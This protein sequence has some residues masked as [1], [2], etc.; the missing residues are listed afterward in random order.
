MIRS[1]TGYGAASVETAVLRASA[2]A[3]S[4]NHRFLE[5]GLRV[6]R[7]LAPLEPE[8]KGLVQSRVARGR[9]D[10]TVVAT[11]LAG[12]PAGVAINRPVIAALVGAL[13]SVQEEFELAGG[14]HIADVARFPGVVEMTDPEGEVAAAH[15]EAVLG[16]IEKA[17]GELGQMRSAEGRALG[18]DV[19]G[20]LDAIDAAGARIEALS[21]EGK[22]QRQAAL[23]EKARS[24]VGELGLEEPRLY[25]EVAR[26]VDR[27]DVAEELQRL[28][29]HVAQ[30]RELLLKGGA[31]GKTFDF[32]A[33]EMLREATTMGSKASSA[34][35]VGQVV[36]L[37]S[38]VER[39]RE[40]AQNVE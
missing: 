7:W 32:L 15:R 18:A 16:V 36:G 14:L 19:A 17:L 2:Q 28:R 1:M 27:S 8:I 5:V 37:K 31:C 26:L 40:Q 22:A 11:L 34:A 12:T 30:T 4:V 25:Q 24:L 20:L 23:V 6:P 29:S 13:R 39:F 9:V 10:V 33:Q 21:A 3:K 35:M 38:E